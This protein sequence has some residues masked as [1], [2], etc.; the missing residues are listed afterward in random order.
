MG[1]EWKILI[2]ILSYPKKYNLE[3]TIDHVI[4]REPD[5][6]TYGDAYLEAGGGYSENLFWRHIKWPNE[7]KALA[8][9]SCSHKK[10]QIIK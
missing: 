8:K 6:I 5:C 4:Q 9:E 1:N 3:T 10:I 2:I 7:I